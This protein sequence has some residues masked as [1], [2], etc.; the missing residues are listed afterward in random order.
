MAKKELTK[1]D[2]INRLV[3]DYE[4]YLNDYDTIDLVKILK[5]NVFTLREALKQEKGIDILK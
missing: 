4:E 1:E 2:I 3:G 5:G